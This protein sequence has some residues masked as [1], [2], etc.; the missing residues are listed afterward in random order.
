MKSKL[1]DNEKQAI[2]NRYLSGEKISHLVQENGIARSTLYSWIKEYK[3]R[4]TKK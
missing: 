2:I 4:A 1:P 3:D